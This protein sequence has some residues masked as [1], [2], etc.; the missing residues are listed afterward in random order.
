[1]SRRRGFTLIEIMVVIVIVGILAGLTLAG[2]QAAR[3]AARRTQCVSNLRQIGL[4]MQQYVSHS[5]VFPC[6]TVLVDLRKNKVYDFSPFVSILPELEQVHL[7]HAVNFDVGQSPIEIFPENATVA[8]TSLRVFLCPSDSSVIRSGEGGMNYRA[9]MGSGT[10]NSARDM[11]RTETGPFEAGQWVR[12]SQVT[13]G[14]ANTV[15]VG[16]KLR[17]DGVEDRWDDRRDFWFSNLA[18]QPVPTTEEVVRH[19]ATVP[20]GATP[21]HQ[22][23]AGS[24]WFRDS[25]G[26]TWYNHAIGP[27]SLAPDC[28]TH[29]AQYGLFDAPGSGIFAGR[30]LHGGGVN[31][32]LADGS[33]RRVGDGVSLAIWRALGTRSGGEVV[34]LP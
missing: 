3:E 18:A 29:G 8:A 28:T 25:Y 6:A 13:D 19:C 20:R 15:L 24:S 9:N 11:E 4:A 5:G 14:L 2:V 10:R 23:W 33:S 34:N 17:G 12:P 26:Q 27:N 31:V 22:S 7:F 21:P 1:M 32:A 30:S 16:E